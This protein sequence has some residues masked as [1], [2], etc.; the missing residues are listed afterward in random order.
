VMHPVMKRRLAPWDEV[1]VRHR[2][3]RWWAKSAEGGR[4]GSTMPREAVSM[5]KGMDERS[6]LRW[7]S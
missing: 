7:G 1:S 3:I 6:K 5:T 2:T 4:D